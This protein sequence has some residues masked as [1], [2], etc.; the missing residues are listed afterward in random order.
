[1]LFKNKAVMNEDG[2][3][4]PSQHNIYVGDNMMSCIKRKLIQALVAASETSF[5]IMGV[6]TLLL[7][8]WAVAMDEWMKSNVHVIQILLRLSL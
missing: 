7:C 2:S 4:Q 3:E 8:P 6:T 1:M 5:I